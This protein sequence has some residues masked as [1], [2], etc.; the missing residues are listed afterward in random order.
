MLL[1]ICSYEVVCELIG[2]LCGILDEISSPFFV[3]VSTPFS[4]LRETLQLDVL[5]EDRTSR[6]L[7]PYYNMR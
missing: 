3:L 7:F 5:V 2:L 6:E 1:L 4:F